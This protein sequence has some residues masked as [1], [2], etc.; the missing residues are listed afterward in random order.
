MG[1]TNTSNINSSAT[2]TE[3]T[4]A[5][6]SGAVVAPATSDENRWITRFE[7]LLK[8]KNIDDLKM[9][10]GKLASE[11]QNEIQNFDINSHL[12]PEAKIRLKTLEARYAKVMRVVHKAQKQFDREFDKSLRVLKRTRQDAEKHLL[13]IKTRITKHRSTLMKASVKASNTLKQKFKA[14]AKKARAKTTVATKKVTRN[15]KSKI[16]KNNN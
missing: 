9:E 3:H 7:D 6:H 4:E 16:T 1:N 2:H 8:V 13:N 5:I 10:L 12:S 11:I 14:T 15:A